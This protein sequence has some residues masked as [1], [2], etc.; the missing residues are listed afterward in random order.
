MLPDIPCSTSL[1]PTLP[2]RRRLIGLLKSFRHTK[3]VAA[4]D[5]DMILDLCE[6]TIVIHDGRV[7]ADGPT[8]EIF[9]DEGLLARSGLEKPLRLQACPVCGRAA[10][11]DASH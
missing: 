2:R 9:R 6:R 3:I 5:L 8:L 4:H 7:M 11:P 10:A 1:R